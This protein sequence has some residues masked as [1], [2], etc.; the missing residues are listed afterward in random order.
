MRFKALRG[1]LLERESPNRTISANGELGPLQM[2]SE[3]DTGRCA[4]EEAV[5]QRGV[6]MRRCAIKD[7]G[8]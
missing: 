7:A 2:V 3:P 1:S 4:N 8:P 6:D 5:P